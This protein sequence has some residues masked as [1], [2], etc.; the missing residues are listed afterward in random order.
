MKLELQSLCVRS[1]TAACKENATIIDD[2]GFSLEGG[3][4]HGLLGPSGAGKSTLMKFIAGR[5]NL[6]TIGN[7]LVFVDGERKSP[8]WRSKHISFMDQDLALQP[9]STVRESLTFAALFKSRYSKT[10]SEIKEKV[11]LVMQSL[12]LSTKADCIIGGEGVDR[13]C[14]IEGLSGGE[15]QRVAFAEHLLDEVS[16]IFVLDEPTSSL[17]SN[18]AQLVIT[19]AKQL[20]HLGKIVLLS[21][22]QPSSRL[23]GEFGNIILLAHGNI[24]HTGGQYATKEFFRSFG[25]GIPVNMCPAERY[26]ELIQDR[27]ITKRIARAVRAVDETRAAR[28]VDDASN[29]IDQ[30]PRE[31][32]EEIKQRS[33]K[34]AMTEISSTYSSSS[35][36]QLFTGVFVID[37]DEECDDD[38]CHCGYDEDKEDTYDDENDNVDKMAHDVEDKL[39]GRGRRGSCSDV[40]PVREEETKIDYSDGRSSRGF[41]NVSCSAADSSF[42]N[43]SSYRYYSLKKNK[44]K[45]NNKEKIRQN[46][47]GTR[48]F[49]SDSCDDDKSPQRRRNEGK[50]VSR[51]HRHHYSA[52]PSKTEEEDEEE[53]MFGLSFSSQFHYLVQRKLRDYWRNRLCLQAQVLNYVGASIIIGSFY[54]TLRKKLDVV[55]NPKEHIG[56]IEVSLIITA[57]APGFNSIAKFEAERRSLRR[58]TSMQLYSLTAYFVS[59][60]MVWMIFELIMGVAFASS[61]HMISGL[62]EGTLF[63]FIGILVV[64]MLVNESIGLLCAVVTPSALLAIMLHT[65]VIWPCALYSKR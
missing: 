24:V 25:F 39:K 28:A 16:D 54:H 15:R 56:A 50:R 40:Y 5:R 8:Q 18:S 59:M 21:I 27:S 2:V 45:S 46:T 62:R 60:S 6:Q 32:M 3:I 51:R 41:G 12:K 34:L 33:G 58:E 36:R 37:R 23:F 52:A 49:I 26:L 48:A 29:E 4:L 31:S 14:R 11:N 44:L 17:D 22:H 35:T 9:T 61:Y 53:G 7:G 55:I 64:F 10:E 42:Y 65:V 47:V 20:C 43:E 1:K 38:L 57:F 63:E 30:D 19:L 13:F